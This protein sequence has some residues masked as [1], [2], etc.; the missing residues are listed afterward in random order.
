[1]PAA[2]VMRSV[3]RMRG[4]LHLALDDVEHALRARLD[5]VGDLPAAGA[6][7]QAAGSAA[8]SR[9]G[10]LLQLHVKSKPSARNASHSSTTR[11]LLHREEIVVEDDVAHAEVDE[12]ATVP[13][14]DYSTLCMRPSLPEVE[15]SQNEHE[16]GQPRLVTSVAT[17]VR[18]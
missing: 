11:C 8:S 12:L 15:R 10:W 14:H 1:M 16:N 18:G 9:F 17:G 4:M 2:R 7:H 5:A 13:Q 6:L 3:S